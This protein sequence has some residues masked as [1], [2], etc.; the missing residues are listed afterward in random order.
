MRRHHG[1]HAGL[2]LTAPTSGRAPAI[3]VDSEGVI[4]LPALVRGRLIM[5][6]AVPRPEIEA[7]FAGAANGPAAEPPTLVKLPEAWVL[8]EPILDRAAMR[9]TGGY[10]YQVLPSVNPRQLPED[11]LDA[12]ADELYELPFAEVLSYLDGLRQAY[13]G[14]RELQR[15]VKALARQ[16][17]EAPDPYVDAGFA[18]FPEMLERG[19][20]EAMVDAE[21]A[22]WQIPGRRFLDGWVEVP[23][24]LYPAPVHLIHA[25]NLPPI[26]DYDP[27]QAAPRIRA[28]PT[29]QLHVT[30]GNS[31]LVPLA[32]LLR[33]LWT[34]SA[35]TVKLPYGAT[36]AGAYL[37]QLAAHAFPDH[38]LTRH[39][40]VL[41]WPGG[42]RQF[43]AP[44]FLPGRYD[45]IVV[46]GAPNAVQSVTE[47]AAFTKTVTFNPRYGVSLIGREAFAHLEQV[48]SR[49]VCD[50]LIQGQKACI[51][52][53]IHYLEGDQAQAE[54][55]AAA[56]RDELGRWDGF[57]PA[58]LSRSQQ[59]Q[60]RRMKRGSFLGATWFE[61]QAGGQFRSAVAVMPNE[62]N[63]ME[64]PLC[65]LIVVRPVPELEQ[66]L[67]YL[68]P[69]VATAGV[70][71]EARRRALS[72]RIGARGVSNVPP[73]GQAGY[74]WPGMPH[75]G[76]LVLSELVDWK[77]A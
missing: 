14:D 59:G 30:A 75:D 25:G 51:A 63:I 57:A 43:E 38:P 48:V 39:L 72:A 2:K 65:R 26:A 12:L 23:G 13:A 35:A 46:W 36:L 17:S 3:S 61:N 31:P 62:F 7:A 21:L 68:H 1:R 60:L 18:V 16:T 66:A 42:D 58:A 9:A 44:L 67:Q 33:A 40:S 74:T 28:L 5:P 55:Y 45:R 77:T 27:A 8:R 64:H 76:M 22:A 29:R 69:G 53:Q 50:T 4:R 49:A 10:Q 32:S 20:A 70:F 47:R 41:Y 54:R 52:S 11:D 37:A 24:T 71:P 34:K 15:Q 19:V 56:L 6:P 73:L